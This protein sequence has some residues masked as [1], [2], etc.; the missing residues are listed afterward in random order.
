VID[1]STNIYQ[2]FLHVHS[3]EHHFELILSIHRLV[4]NRQHNVLT[5]GHLI[6]HWFSLDS[7]YIDSNRQ[8]LNNRN[9]FVVILDW[10]ELSTS[11]DRHFHW[12]FVRLNQ[13]CRWTRNRTMKQR[14]LE[15]ITNNKLDCTM[16]IRSAIY[17]RWFHLWICHRLFTILH[18]IH[19]AND[20]FSTFTVC[21]VET[22]NVLVDSYISFFHLCIVHK[23]RR[24]TNDK[25]QFN[26]LLYR[27]HRHAVLSFLRIANRIS[28]HW[29]FELL[30]VCNEKNRTDNNI[31]ANG[32]F[33]SRLSMLINEE[34]QYT[35]FCVQF[36][37]TTCDLPISWSNQ[38]C[39]ELTRRWFV[40]SRSSSFDRLHPLSNN[41]PWF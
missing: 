37:C 35:P 2:D 23:Q 19:D 15:I 17:W 41:M 5:I 21:H 20:I 36:K 40:R 9:T 18:I 11:L 1:S 13:S 14:N 38:S 24:K 39:T 32:T 25:E 30:I 31:V 12:P 28:I 22:K 10:V 7:K 6:S 26:A 29:D 34:A 3:L 4:Q 16:N 8:Y 27:W 33:S